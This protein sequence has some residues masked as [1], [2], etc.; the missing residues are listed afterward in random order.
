MV[1]GHHAQRR[2]DHR[3]QF[4]RRGAVRGRIRVHDHHVPAVH[5]QVGPQVLVDERDEPRK[6]AVGD[7][8]A[9]TEVSVGD[10]HDAHAQSL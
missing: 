4:E 1:T 5:D 10:L 6:V 8:T 9:V 3:G 7:A 2:R